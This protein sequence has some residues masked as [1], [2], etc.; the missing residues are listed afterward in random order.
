[1]HITVAEK[2]V[3]HC[4]ELDQQELRF[5]LLFWDEIGIPTNNVEPRCLSATENFLHQEG[6]LNRWATNWMC[7]LDDDEMYRDSFL[8]AFWRLRKIQPGKWSA[9][10]GGR[11]ISWPLK[12]HADARSIIVRLEHCVPVPGVNVPLG[13][14]LQFRQKRQTEILAFRAAF[15]QLC[16]P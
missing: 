16:R 3:V 4:R 7:D 13:D 14:I 12:E 6:L 10:I 2:T 9:A 1:N 8:F 15:E 5:W 11:S